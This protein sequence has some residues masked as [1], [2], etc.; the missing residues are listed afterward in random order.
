MFSKTCKYGI[1][2]TLFVAQ[3]SNNGK[4]VLLKDIANA[5]KSPTAFTGKIMQNLTKAKVIS[6]IKGPNGGFEIAKEDLT[7]ISIK[8]IVVALDGN[9]IFTGCALGLE[10]CDAKTPCPMHDTFEKIRR[11][12]NTSLM[13]YNLLST[14]ENLNLGLTVLKR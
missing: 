7:K 5:I 8:D 1:K 12:I 3:N 13:A 11:D 4:R 10:I 14:S 6:S 9:E 2:A